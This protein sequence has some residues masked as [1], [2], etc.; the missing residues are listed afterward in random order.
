ME[1][2]QLS[3]AQGKPADFDGFWERSME[4]L[5]R[6]PARPEIDTIPL[7]DT[8]F[9]TMY[10]VRLTGVGPYRLFAYLSIPNG[11]GPFPAI[12]YAAK[13]GSVVEPIPQGAPN[14]LRSRYVTLSVA[15]RGQRNA[16]QPFAADFPGLLTEGMESAESYVYRGVALDCVRGLEFLLSRPEVDSSRIVATGNDMALVAAALHGGVTHVV[17]APA[18]FFDATSVAPDTG[19]YPM[20]EFNDY[21]RLH[22]DAAGAVGRTLSYLDPRWFAPRVRATTLLMAE[23]PGGL[24]DRQ[25][26]APL[27]EGLAGEV[28]VHDSE[29]SSYKDGLFVE[30]WLTR[31][32]GFKEPIVPEHW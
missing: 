10:G 3:E 2:N 23:A 20:E 16:D 9:A 17:C 1:V 6:Y 14:L 25:R 4:E 24:L 8:D 5:S 19:A 18:I 31:Q 29:S 26:L 22:P 13:Y 15:T 27:S 7:R 11:E 32:L 12:Y 21:I 30:H 28:E